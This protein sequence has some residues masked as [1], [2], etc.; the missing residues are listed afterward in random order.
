MRHLKAGR[1]F[2]RDTDHRKALMRNLSTSLLESGR[3]T[4]T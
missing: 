3:I 4:T 2:N 1:K